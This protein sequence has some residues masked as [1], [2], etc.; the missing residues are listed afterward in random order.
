MRG[1]GVSVAVVLA[2]L[3]AVAAAHGINEVVERRYR[4]AFG[5][6]VDKSGGVTAD[7]VDCN[8]KDSS[9]RTAG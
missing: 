7:L 8:W 1:L 4:P 6:C 5:Q 3:P 2:G 9:F